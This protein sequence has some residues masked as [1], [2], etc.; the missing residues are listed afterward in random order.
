MGLCSV[1]EMPRKGGAMD[2]NKIYLPLRTKALP[3]Y[4]RTV[5]Q[6]LL[7]HVTKVGFKVLRHS[8]TNI[9][10]FLFTA[11]GGTSISTEFF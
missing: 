5:L 8:T 1:T 2:Q 7:R 9:D 10:I 4:P 3:V 11:P 6:G